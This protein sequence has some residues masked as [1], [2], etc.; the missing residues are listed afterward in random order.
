[1]RADIEAAPMYD[2]IDPSRTSEFSRAILQGFMAKQDAGDRW[3]LALVGLL[4]DERLV[5]DI[6]AAD[7]R[8]G[9]SQPRKT[10]GI[11]GTG[12]QR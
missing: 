8:L 1:M 6:V 7:P 4:S 2:M 10:G 9:R 12:A 5:P 11:C 3:A